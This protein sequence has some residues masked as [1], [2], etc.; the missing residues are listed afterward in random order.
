VARSRLLAVPL[1]TAAARLALASPRRQ[2]SEFWAATGRRAAPRAE[3][4]AALALAAAFP[5][6]FDTD[7]VLAS[8]PAR[9]PPRPRARRGASSGSAGAGAAAGL[10]PAA[11][12]LAALEGVLNRTRPL[13]KFQGDADARPRPHGIHPLVVQSPMVDDDAAAAAMTFIYTATTRGAA[14]GLWPQAAR[15]PPGGYGPL[16]VSAPQATEASVVEA[17]GMALGGQE[18]CNLNPAPG[19][20]GGVLMERAPSLQRPGAPGGPPGGGPGGGAAPGFSN[21]S[22]GVTAAMRARAARALPALPQNLRE[23]LQV[24]GGPPPSDCI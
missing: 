23:D 11:A 21:G 4:A 13:G 20:E 9:A 2:W 17:L 5:P 16:I 10:P 18:Y 6:A 24:R 3:R 19:G 1:L 8:A 7:S 15:A 22:R 12:T 14:R